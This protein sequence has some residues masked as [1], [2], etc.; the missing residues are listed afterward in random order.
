MLYRRPH[1]ILKDTTNR[2]VKLHLIFPN[3]ILPNTFESYGIIYFLSFTIT[4]STMNIVFFL[5]SLQLSFH[6]FIQWVQSW[7]IPHLYHPSSILQCTVRKSSYYN[8][9]WKDVM[10]EAALPS[11][12]KI[13]E[14]SLV[15]GCG[16]YSL[17]FK[18][19]ME[20]LCIMKQEVVTYLI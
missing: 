17:L 4:K 20:K 8:Y 14:S 2:K 7:S 9:Q 11:V 12:L 1:I 13:M 18:D 19:N 15:G 3:T 16:I 6:R 10:G 5:K